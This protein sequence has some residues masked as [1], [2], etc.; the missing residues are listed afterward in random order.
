MWGTQ[1]LLENTGSDGKHEVWWEARGLV[2]NT[3]SGGKHG[4]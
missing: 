3:G 2:E 4:V 1:G